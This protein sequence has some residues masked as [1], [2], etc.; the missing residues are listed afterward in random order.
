MKGLLHSKKFKKNLYKWLFMYICVMLLF[1]SVVTYSKY[2]STFLSTSTARV[3]KF[4][5]GIEG[6]N[7][8]NEENTSKCDI[9]IKRPTGEITYTFVVKPE[10]E[11]KTNVYMS[12]L[13]NTNF[14][15]IKLEKINLDGTKEEVSTTNGGL[16][17]LTSAVDSSTTNFN[18][19]SWCLFGG[20][21]KTSCQTNSLDGEEDKKYQVTIKY[22][23]NNADY[24][25][26]NDKTY[27]IL[28][29]GFSAIQIT[30]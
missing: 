26:V 14:K 15:L 21:S 20:D 29:V 17:T 6:E 8:T 28:R 1:T 7:C 30:N 23:A 18:T 9:G 5:V 10:L 27:D 12:I 25:S 3:A 4:K 13:L 22:I 19:Y 2:I 24:T 16:D 11:V